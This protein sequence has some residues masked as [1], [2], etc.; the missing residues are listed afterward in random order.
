MNNNVGLNHKGYVVS[1]S[2][3]ALIALVL[4]VME[5]YAIKP[6]G[7]LKSACGLEI[8][9]SL[10]GFESNM[11]DGRTLFRIEFVSVDTSVKQ[12]PNAVEYNT[13][14]IVLK[15]QIL[16]SFW[17]HYS[18]L[19]DFHSHAYSHVNDVEE[20]RGYF[21][22]E[23][24]IEDLEENQ[25]FYH[26]LGAR[27]SLLVTVA[28][29]HR[30]SNTQPDWLNHYSC[31]SFTMSNV[32]VWISANCLYKKDGRLKYISA[33]DDLVFMDCPTVLGFTGE[34]VDFGRVQIQSKGQPRY[35][36]I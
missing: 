30:A 21:L 27:L 31:F 32:R 29:L 9:G 6:K 5:A 2:E 12:A 13:E 35:N 25:N 24:D 20:V 19:G 16:N 33:Q 26:E 36:A 22:S 7:K 23:G 1:I 3:N 17:P 28:S 14:A 34:W 15:S 11:A 18:Y 8:F 10:Y 4:N